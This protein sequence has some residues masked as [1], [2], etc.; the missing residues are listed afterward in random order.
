KTGRP[1]EAR[2]LCEQ[3]LALC[4]EVGDRR[5]EGLC[6]EN[7]A[8]LHQNQGSMEEARTL[9]EQAL[10]LLREVGDRS[11]E[12]IFLN[13]FAEFERWERGDREE[14]ERLCAK[15]EEILTEVNDKLEL[16]RL[17]CTRGHLL[18]WGEKSA[19]SLLAQART[20]AGEIGAGQ[21]S[22]FGKKLSVLARAE[23]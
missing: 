9:Y 5:Q 23:E 21:E 8:S 12:G 13:E 19:S 11:F 6:Q 1:E 2:A 18:L 3:A 22:N 14:V 10:A 17:F 4:R 20:L 15:A 7:L 16:G